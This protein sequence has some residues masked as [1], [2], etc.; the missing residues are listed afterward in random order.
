M[1]IERLK[2]ILDYSRNNQEEVNTMVRKFFAIAG[3]DSNSDV[4]KILQ[5]VRSSFKKRGYLVIEMPLQDLEIGAFSYK[6][7]GLGYVVVNTSLPRVNINFA[8]AHEIYHIFF[9]TNQFVSKIKFTTDNYY[10]HEDEYA[11]NLFAGMLLM[12]EFSFRKMFRTFYDESAQDEVDTLVRLMTYY[13]VPYTAVLIRCYEL[14]LLSS[15][16]IAQKLLNITQDQIRDRIVDLWLDEEVLNPTNKNDYH[17][18]F[19]LVERM[20]REYIEKQFINERTL[21]K[22]LENMGTIYT[23]IRGI[24]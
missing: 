24:R 15:A 22:V 14:Q 9:Q 23:E 10:E 7:D 1:D 21:K 16:S 13:D 5:I 12:P 20:G 4:L 8:L 2:K 18:L 11:A 17:H 6:G 19:A 3:L